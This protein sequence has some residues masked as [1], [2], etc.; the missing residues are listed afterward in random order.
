M[1]PERTTTLF[2][3]M[4]RKTRLHYLTTCLLAGSAMH[5]IYWGLIYK[6]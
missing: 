4:S 1:D 2:T 6:P 3:N 5:F